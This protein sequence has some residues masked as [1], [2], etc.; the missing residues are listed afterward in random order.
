M[1]GRELVVRRERRVRRRRSL[2]WQS[3][4]PSLISNSL[5]LLNS[6]PKR[7]ESEEKG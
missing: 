1:G 4:P 7:K 5:S 2:L 3:R 6:D